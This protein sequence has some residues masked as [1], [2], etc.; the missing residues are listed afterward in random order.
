M[1]G[2]P[3]KFGL[4]PPHPGEFIPDEIL[5]E[6]ERERSGRRAEC[7]ARFSLTS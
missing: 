5:A 2:T 6:L 7:A 4:T 1:S 3:R